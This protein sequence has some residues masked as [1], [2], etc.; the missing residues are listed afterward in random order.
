MFVNTFLWSTWQSALIGAPIRLMPEVVRWKQSV[1][2]IFCHVLI[3]S[4]PIQFIFKLGMHL[5][6]FPSGRNS[7]LRANVGVAWDLFLVHVLV[8]VLEFRNKIQWARKTCSLSL[9]GNPQST[10]NWILL[11]YFCNERK[12]SK[13][14]SLFSSRQVKCITLG[15]F[16]G[17]AT[18]SYGC[19]VV[20]FVRF[21]F[22]QYL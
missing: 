14:R 18:K 6:Q 20:M 22:E 12:Q 4:T 11:F 10:A 9:L 15:R 5:M 8:Y 3:L 13:T 7:S 1:S 19:A 17:A 16:L 2:G 21:T